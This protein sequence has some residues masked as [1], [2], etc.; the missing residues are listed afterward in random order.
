MTSSPDTTPLTHFIKK[1][2][3]QVEKTIRTDLASALAGNDPLLVEV[4]HY[5][6]LGGG[7]R[8]RPMLAILSSRL[9]GRDDDELYL[10]AA[11]FEYLHVATLIHDD[12]IDHANSRRG[13][14]SVRKK[15]GTASAILAGDWLHARSMH[16]IGSLTGQEGLDIFCGATTAMVDGEF[17]QLRHVA[18]TDVT[19][20]Q[21]FDVI[22]RKTARLISST[23]EIGA[24]FGKG[25]PEQISAL[26]TYGRKTGIGFQIVDDLLDYLGD[27]KATGK[28]IGNDFVEGKLTLPLIHALNRA[29]TSDRTTLLACINGDR[30]LPD[31]C[32]T[33]K[34]LM[35]DIGSF[36][37][38]RQRAEKEIQQ[39]LAGLS[40][41]DSSKH[42]ESL[43]IL[44]GLAEY[45]LRRD[46]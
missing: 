42:K 7:K 37:Y 9:C 29:D 38:A 10:L 32:S 46:R 40:V 39:G 6:L 31:A 12:V 45:I 16:L 14:E 20:K 27:A 1:I 17:L 15:F 22:L 2:A 36:D 8:V 35:R 43:T 5:A 23:C 30:S 18:D 3:E 21:Y 33:A 25:R 19:E 11:A 4:L 41:F 34:H 26:A 28:L 44:K 24:V 13:K